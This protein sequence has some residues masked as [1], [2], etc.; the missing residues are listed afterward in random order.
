MRIKKLMD[1]IYESTNAENRKIGRLVLNNLT[2]LYFLP[3]ESENEVTNTTHL[4]LN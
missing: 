2:S 3:N 4:L 1:I